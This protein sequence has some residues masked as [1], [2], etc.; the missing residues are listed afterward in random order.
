MNRGVAAA[1]LT[2]IRAADTDIVCSIDC[3]CTYDPLQLES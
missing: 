1:I 2:G 3:D